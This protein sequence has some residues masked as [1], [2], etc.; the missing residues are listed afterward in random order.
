[1]IAIV[2]IIC[3]KFGEIQSIFF[4]K[5]KLCLPDYVKRNQKKILI[6]NL[7]ECSTKCYYHRS[8]CDTNPKKDDN[9]KFFFYQ[10][11]DAIY[12]PI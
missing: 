11:I 1:M 9:V 3:D 5:Y 7:N 10:K 12:F 2:L 6:F 4:I 8:M